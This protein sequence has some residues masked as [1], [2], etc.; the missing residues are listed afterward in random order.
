MSVSII[1]RQKMDSVFVRRWL[2]YQ[3]TVTYM[4]YMASGMD[5]HT[6]I[7]IKVI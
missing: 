7:C 3:N 5:I 6:D 2:V 4:Y 1:Y